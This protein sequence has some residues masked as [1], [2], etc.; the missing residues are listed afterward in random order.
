MIGFGAEV[1]LHNRYKPV[2]EL[3]LGMADHKPSGNNYTYKSPMSLFMRI[4]M[5]YNFLYNSSPDYQFM[6]SALRFFIVQIFDRQHNRRCALLGR[7]RQIRHTV[8][9]FD[10]RVDGICPG[11]EGKTMGPHI[12]RLGFQ[13]SL[14]T[15]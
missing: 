7:S 3:G 15:P 9:D 8:A 11:T 4:G 2:F 10:S 12:G 1:S 13:I 14:D 6:R 5:N